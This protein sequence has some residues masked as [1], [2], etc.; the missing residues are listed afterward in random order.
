MWDYR[1]R[2]YRPPNK[3]GGLL[4][5]TV[6]KGEAS[7]DAE[8]AAFQARMKRGEISHVEVISFVEPYGVTTI[9]ERRE[10]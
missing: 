5:E 6:H 8:L 9:Y 2:A 10:A 7:R 1:I 4:I 3:G